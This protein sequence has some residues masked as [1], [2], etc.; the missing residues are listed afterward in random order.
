LDFLVCIEAQQKNG[1]AVGKPRKK[2]SDAGITCGKCKR[3]DKENI[4]PKSKRSKASQHTTKK[5]LKGKP[6][7]PS[8]TEFISSSGED[9]EDREDDGDMSSEGSD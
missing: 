1:K 9:D 5:A 6:K 3:G 7:Q 8:S 4:G 2:R